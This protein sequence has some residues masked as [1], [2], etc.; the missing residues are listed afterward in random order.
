MLVPFLIML[1]EGLEAALIVGIVAGYL[2]RSGRAAWMPAVW[3]GIFLAAALALFVGAG[4]QLASAEFP[5]RT[6]ELFEAGVGFVAVAILTSM[7]LWMRKAARS[8]KAEL[9]TSVDAAL[10]GSSARGLALVG[11]VFFA[12]AREG[13]ESVFF[14]L[15]IFQQSPGAAGPLGALLGLLVSA[16]LG[17][18]IYR[19]GVRL[20]LARFFR[21]TGVFILFVAAGLLAGALRHLHEAGVWNAMQGVAFDL[22]PILPED[23]LVGSVLA[24]LFGYMASPRVGELLAYVLY[25]AVALTLFLRP[26][27]PRSAGARPAAALR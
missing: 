24:G 15:A 21:W 10:T 25:L 7:V 16:L 12:V 9:Q 11:L 14:L 4:L 13:L 5:Q 2:T 27:A 18:G 23:G 1:R 22:S 17:Y 8:L 19:G 20:D 3:I 26:A 6:Q